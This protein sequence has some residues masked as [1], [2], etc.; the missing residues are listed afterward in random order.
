MILTTLLAGVFTIGVIIIVHELGHF[1]AA[2]AVG[3]HVHRFSV[4]MGPVILRKRGF[5]T[6]WALSL[7][8]LGGYV[9]MAGME[10]APMEGGEFDETA[11][12]PESLYRNKSLGA[13]FL[14]IIGGPLANLILAALISIGLLWAGGETIFPT[15][16]LADPTADSP[17]AAL[18]IQRGDRLA[19]VSGE[20]VDD[21]NSVD[22]L[23]RADDSSPV[24]IV[25]DR[26][27]QVLNLAIERPEEGLGWGLIPLFD[28]R[29]GRV[30][31][32]GPAFEAGLREGDAIVEVDGKPVQFFEEIA[33]II[34]T[35]A[36]EETLI[37]WDHEGTL[38]EAR[39]TPEASEVPNADGSVEVI[40]R[41]FFE[42]YLGSRPIG[43]W[44]AVTG[45]LDRTFGYVAVTLDFLK[46]AVFFRVSAD[47]VGGPIAIFQMAG[48][49]AGWGFSNLLFFIAFFST[50]LFLL[51]LLPI[52]V[53]DGGHII[54]MIPELFGREVSENLRLRL[55]QAGLVLLLGI[56]VLVVFND[57][58]RII[59]G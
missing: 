10:L 24:S 1:L 16:W 40:G 41:I 2:R 36:G 20:E 51:N 3:I 26:E 4:G 23:L 50:Q 42:P 19:R 38:M 34:N 35:R 11:L 25:V 57:L 13:R 49:M 32:D 17:A 54:L 47:A 53:L 48:Q 8:P 29:V 37:R 45:G 59:G 22:R 28:N 9:R 31:K 18:D 46:E 7:L 58:R 52:P 21:W 5:G 12:P 27:G 33:E 15:T 14:A 6:E 30:L 44:G 39:L 43:I 56:I 55:T